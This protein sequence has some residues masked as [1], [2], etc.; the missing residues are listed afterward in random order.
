MEHLKDSAGL[1]EAG[2]D[3]HGCSRSGSN[4]DR[5]HANADTGGW[6]PSDPAFSQMAPMEDVGNQR[7]PPQSEVPL[8]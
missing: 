2:A 6:V 5:F 1:Y 3:W 4:D 8:R 7:K